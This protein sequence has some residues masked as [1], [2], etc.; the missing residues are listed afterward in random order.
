MD[1]W[2]ALCSCLIS[3]TAT[4]HKVHLSARG[5]VLVQFG[6]DPLF[7]SGATAAS[8][9]NDQT[10]KA[11][12]TQCQGA[13]SASSCSCSG[14]QGCRKPSRSSVVD[15]QRSTEGIQGAEGDCAGSRHLPSASKGVACERQVLVPGNPG[16]E[17]GR[18]RAG[19]QDVALE[20]YL[21]PHEPAA[22]P[23]L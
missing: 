17:A 4:I 5:L 12:D 16:Q 14:G 2:S 19:E 13:A 8:G 1:G 7:L 11:A 3:Q 20:R 21:P 22:C 6:A 9:I 15:V 18:G 10:R 23:K